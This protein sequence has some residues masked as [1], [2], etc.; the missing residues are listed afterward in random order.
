MKSIR[1][2]LILAVLVLLACQGCG[3][4]SG[5]DGPH[6]G[7]W[8]TVYYQSIYGA[9]TTELVADKSPLGITI[10]T[11]THFSYQWK[12]SPNSAAGTYTYDGKVIH[13][14]FEYLE[15]SMFAG[16]TL[17]FDME[18]R[19]DSI[20]ISGPTKAVSPTGSDLMGMV[21]QLYEIRRR[22]K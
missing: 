10:F 9:D 6:L 19:N 17:T 3:R 13:Q 20:I 4:Y 16:A 1:Y 7:V 12:D 22:V 14:R 5:G 2:T 18:V 15:A 8:E 11:P 21:Q